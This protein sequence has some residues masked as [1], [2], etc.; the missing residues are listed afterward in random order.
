MHDDRNHLGFRMHAY[1]NAKPGTDIRSNRMKNN[2]K[3]GEYLHL[4]L[5]KSSITVKIPGRTIPATDGHVRRGSS[6]T[7]SRLGQT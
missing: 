4:K 5:P 1:N 6:K 2:V 7:S 3:Y